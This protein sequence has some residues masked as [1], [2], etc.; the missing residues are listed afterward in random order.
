ML[1]QFSKINDVYFPN[2]KSNAN[3]H[4]NLFFSLCYFHSVLEGRKKY[5]ALGWN[6]PYQF[7]FADFEISAGQIQ[8]IV[9]KD[10]IDPKHH[11]RLAKY[12]VGEIN[13]A[14]KLQRDND[15]STLNAILEDLFSESI[16]FSNGLEAD[17]QMSHLGY[18][19]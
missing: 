17:K 14:G 4:K 3:L 11:V 19:A 15:F 10:S 16:A 1:R 18:P 12:L 9:M 7:D 13:Y 8:R 2:S 6:V 5:G